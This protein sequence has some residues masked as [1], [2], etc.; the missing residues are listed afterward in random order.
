MLVYFFG[1]DIILRCIIRLKNLKLILF[2]YRNGIYLA[3]TV[4]L[5]IPLAITVPEPSSVIKGPLVAEVPVIL[6]TSA[7]VLVGFSFF[8]QECTD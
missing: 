3:I 6:P 2:L 4:L 8:L 7:V 5:Q 1:F